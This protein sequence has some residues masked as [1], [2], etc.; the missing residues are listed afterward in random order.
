MIKKVQSMN[1]INGYQPLLTAQE[2]CEFLS[3][4]ETTL[5]RLQVE[6]KLVPDFVIGKSRRYSQAKLLVQMQLNFGMAA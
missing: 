1:D 4:S 2:V 6:G 5:Y 3:I